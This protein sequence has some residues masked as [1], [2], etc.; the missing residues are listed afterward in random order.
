MQLNTLANLSIFYTVWKVY[1]TRIKN[2]IYFYDCFMDQS[3]KFCD[4]VLNRFGQT[5][6]Y[7]HSLLEP[8]PLPPRNECRCWSAPAVLNQGFFA[9]VNSNKTTQSQ[10]SMYLNMLREST[11]LRLVFLTILGEE[12]EG[13]GP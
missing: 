6:T 12:L 9:W 11:T 13:G 10:I 4:P 5:N 8:K 1:T 3:Y 2:E 7:T